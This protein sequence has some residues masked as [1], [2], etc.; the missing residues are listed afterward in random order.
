MEHCPELMNFLVERAREQALR[1]FQTMLP[2]LEI[3]VDQVL[4]PQVFGQ[5]YRRYFFF[6]KG[7]HFTATSVT[8]TLEGI[9]KILD[10]NPD[11]K[12]AQ[13]LYRM[14]GDE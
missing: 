1:D 12:Q 8:Y 7:H 6:L 3:T 9:E 2:G 11:L 4:G 13:V 14:R 5:T 10:S